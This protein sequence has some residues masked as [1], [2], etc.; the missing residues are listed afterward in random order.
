MEHRSVEQA[1]RK[2]MM[3]CQRF[4]RRMRQCGASDIYQGGENEPPSADRACLALFQSL[5]NEFQKN[6]R[7]VVALSVRALSKTQIPP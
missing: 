3:L 1:R 6:Y 7:Q 4:K 2:S 5:D